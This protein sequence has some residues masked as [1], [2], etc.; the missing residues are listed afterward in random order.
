MN[1]NSR[2]GEQNGMYGVHRTGAANPFYGKKHSEE[3]KAKISLA[4][5]GIMFGPK[6][7]LW[8]GDTVSLQGLHKWVIRHLGQPNE[9]EHCGKVATGHDMQWA[10]VSGEYK[11]ELT[12]WKRLCAKCHFAFDE[13]YNRLRVGGRLQAGSGRTN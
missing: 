4:K 5:K 11:R 1:K 8:K 12:D 3:T 10:N 13:Q 6:H 9:C 2:P 7:H